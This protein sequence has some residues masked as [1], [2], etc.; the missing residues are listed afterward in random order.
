MLSLA[1]TTSERE[2][3]K[4][5]YQHTQAHKHQNTSIELGL[6]HEKQSELW[7]L[8]YESI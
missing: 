1:S 6:L 2:K 8:D 4:H 7:L 5:K 3:K